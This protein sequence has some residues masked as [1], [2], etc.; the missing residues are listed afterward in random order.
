MSNKSPMVKIQ[1]GDKVLIEVPL[2]ELERKLEEAKKEK[3]GDWTDVLAV[4]LGLIAC[5][6]FILFIAFVVSLLLVGIGLIF[7]GGSS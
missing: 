4:I 3:E 7:F 2:E 1:D 5:S 6:P